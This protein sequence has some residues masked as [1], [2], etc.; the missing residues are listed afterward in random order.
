MPILFTLKIH[1]TGTE[2]QSYEEQNKMK[3]LDWL[4]TFI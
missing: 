1:V 2:D 3:P 4:C